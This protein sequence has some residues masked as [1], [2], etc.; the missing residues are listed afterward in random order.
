VYV[1]GYGGILRS[2]DGGDSW[3]HV[4][5]DPINKSYCTDIAIAS[6]GIIY[7]ALGTFS[8]N[9]QGLMSTVFGIWKSEDGINWASITPEGFPSQ[10]RTINIE[11]AESNPNSLYVLTENPHQDPDPVLGF[12]NSI[13]TFWKA[14]HLDT[15]NILWEDRTANIPGKG[16]GNIAIGAIDPPHGYNS[17]G[18][19]AFTL[20]IHPQDED[21]VFLGGTNLYGN[22]SGFSDSTFTKVYGGYPYD[23]DHAN[24]H[25]DIHDVHVLPSSP[26][27]LFVATDGGIYNTM[28]C[29]ADST[30]W[31]WLSENMNTTQFYWVGIDHASSNDEFVVGGCQD[32]AVYYH[33]RYFPGQAWGTIMGGDGLT[34]IVADNKEYAVVSVYSGN[35]F[36]VTFNDDMDI[37]NEIYQR[38]DIASDKDFSFFTTFSIDRVNNKTFYMAALNRILR[39]DDMAAAANDTSLVNIGWEWIENTG[40]M[41]DEVITSI[42]TSVEPADIIYYGSNNGKMFRMENASTPNPVVTEI[43]GC[44]FPTNG[45]IGYIEVDPTNAN[46]IFVAFSNYNIQSL[47]HSDDAGA[48]WTNISGNLEENQDGSGGGPSVRCIRMLNYEDGTGY[49]AA[50]SAGLFS[51]YELNGDQTIWVQEGA[52]IIG[53]MIIDHID[54]RETDGWMVIATQGSGIYQT[55]FEPSG[56]D[57]ND[58]VTKFELQ[59]PYPNPCKDKA[60]VKFSIQEPSQ[61]QLEIYDISGRKISSVEEGFYTRGEY[62][63]EINTSDLQPGSYFLKLRAGDQQTNRKIIVM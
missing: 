36:S 59:C 22:T 34:C 48:T 44:N 2:V 20:K 14:S 16:L 8:T 29:Y 43:T 62:Q 3:S 17:I 49:F 53:N 58:I 40:I 33:D 23:G 31:G 18:G 5:G 52:N 38:P 11:I 28:D 32:N 39:K 37:E 51:T 42:N 41:P 60:T 50:T 15:D 25:P 24:L 27:S 10:Y 35:I 21:F 4:L 54:C 30:V 46:N 45:F 26:A 57:N 7:A 19:Y 56:I 47:F 63:T 9:E 13:H 6:N 55:H 1:A 61:I 12:S